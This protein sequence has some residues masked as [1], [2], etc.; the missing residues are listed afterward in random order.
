MTTPHAPTREDLAPLR[1]SFSKVDT[2][3]SCPLKY[4]YRYL[5]KLPTSASP[6]MSWGSSIHAGL[7]AWWHPSTVGG[8]PPTQVMTA[9]LYRSWDRRGFRT[10]ARDD[11]LAWYREAQQVLRRHHEQHAQSY[12]PAVAVEQWF[13]LELDEQVTVVGAIDKVERAEAGTLAI[14]DWK[15]SRKP[16]DRDQ[17]AASLQLAVY[18]LA[19][20]QL[21]D[22]QVATVGFD[23]VVPGVQVSVPV[24]QIDTDAAVAQILAAAAEIRAGRY[25]ATPS[26]LCGWCDFRDRCPMFDGDGPD[27]AGL[28][29]TERRE[30]LRRMER[31]R[32]RLAELEPVIVAAL[33]D[34]AL[35]DVVTVLTD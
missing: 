33:G 31:D 30:L 11:E 17:V 27:L 18:A 6:E 5:D 32:Q 20:R 15:T 35:D 2:Y 28:A 26:K 22:N 12:T 24:D 4:R 16:R 3:Q 8:P 7:A 23:Y 19:A 34:D 13:T 25:P 9:A 10:M 29:V 14:R 21:W 1:L